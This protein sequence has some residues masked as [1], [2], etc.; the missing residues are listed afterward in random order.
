MYCAFHDEGR[1]YTLGTMRAKKVTEQAQSKRMT[2]PAFVA[3]V[4]G[5]GVL[6]IVGAILI[7]KSDNGQINV[8]AA[9]EQSNKANI[10]A[11]G[12]GA[13]QVETVP[14][15]FKN[16]PNGGLVPQENQTAETPTPTEVGAGTTTDAIPNDSAS[17]TVSMEQSDISTQGTTEVSSDEGAP[18]GQ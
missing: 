18:V 16:M 5:V 12:E 6:V 10:E 2:T 3:S 9:I 4:L 7:G 13:T 1:W 11:Y 15:E 8:T 17:S 14:D